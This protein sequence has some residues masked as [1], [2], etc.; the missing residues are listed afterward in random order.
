MNKKA[1][2]AFNNNSSEL[3]ISDLRIWVYLGCSLEEK[4]H[5]QPISIDINL[6]F[7][8]MPVAINTDNIADVICYAKLTKLAKLAAEQKKYNLIEHLAANIHKAIIT[9][10]LQA[11]YKDTSLKIKVT[12]MKPPIDGVHGG[13]S[14]IYNV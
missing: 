1:E 14:F 2:V 8:T 5:K 12:K 7:T 3:I 9:E 10:V 11:G 4:H 13:V 6:L